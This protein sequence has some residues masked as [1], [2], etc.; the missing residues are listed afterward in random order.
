MPSASLGRRAWSRNRQAAPRGRDTARLVVEKVGAGHVLY[1][2]DTPAAH[3]AQ[4]ARHQA[5]RGFAS[6]PWRA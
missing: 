2:S 5:V 6:T 1:G 4:A 3:L